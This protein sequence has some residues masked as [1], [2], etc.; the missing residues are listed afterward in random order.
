[1]KCEQHFYIGICLHEFP[2]HTTGSII[3]GCGV[4]FKHCIPIVLLPFGRVGNIIPEIKMGFIVFV[5]QHLEHVIAWI[6]EFFEGGI[7]G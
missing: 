5:L 7:G 3:N 6:S 4:M 2:P 1:M